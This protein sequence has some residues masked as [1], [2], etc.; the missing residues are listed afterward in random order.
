MDLH[1][2][3]ALARRYYDEVWNQ[4]RLAF[5]D[6]H[7]TADYENCDPVTPGGVLRGREAFRGFVTAFRDAMPDLR[8]DIYEQRADGDAVVSYWRASGT[9]RGPLMGIA[10]TGRHLDGIEGVTTTT[11]VDGRI[12]RDRAVWDVA[13]LLRGLGVLPAPGPSVGERNIETVKSLYDAFGRGDVAFILE[14][15]APDVSWGIASASADVVPPYGVGSGRDAVARF[16]GAWAQTVDFTA[17]AVDGFVAVGDHVFNLLHYEAVVRATG[18]T[19]RNPGCMQHWTVVDG[20]VVR[21][22]GYE[23]TAATRAAY[24]G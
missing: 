10:A 15:V 19:V 16:A 24:L 6:E 12:V 2:M 20:K 21:W 5:I 13:G 1:A 23:D 9:Q 18:E 17:F 7:M 14:R 4:G 3:K 8:L 11:I 22:R